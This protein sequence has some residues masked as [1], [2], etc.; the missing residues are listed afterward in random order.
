MHKFYT[1]IV[2]ILT[3]LIFG[4]GKCLSDADDDSFTAYFSWILL[5]ICA[6]ADV[7]FILMSFHN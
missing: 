6:L 4:F 7:L 2:F 1:L 5:T 3:L